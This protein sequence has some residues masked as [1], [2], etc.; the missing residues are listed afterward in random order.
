MLVA[1]CFD[2]HFRRKRRPNLRRRCWSSGS[3]GRTDSIAEDV[4]LLQIRPAFVLDRCYKLGVI[5]GERSNP[6]EQQGEVLGR[7]GVA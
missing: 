1:H 4:S 3:L 5:Y 6:L 2:A 7:E